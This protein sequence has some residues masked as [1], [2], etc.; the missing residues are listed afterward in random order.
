MTVK[1]TLLDKTDDELFAM[2]Q[3]IAREKLRRKQEPRRPVYWTDSQYMK[4]LPAALKTLKDDAERLL[5]FPG[6]PEAY[7]K[8]AIAEGVSSE[9]LSLKIEFWNESD[10]RARGDVTHGS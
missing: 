10:Y 6:G 3:A 1:D 8:G 9:L 7:F 2:E 4:S 5:S